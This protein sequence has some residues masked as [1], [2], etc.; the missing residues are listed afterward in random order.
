[1][2]APSEG[3][4]DT[5]LKVL[6]PPPPALRLRCSCLLFNLAVEWAEGLN[7]S[8]FNFMLEDLQW[9]LSG[10]R[11]ALF[12]LLAARLPGSQAG[13]QLVGHLPGRAEV[14]ISLLAL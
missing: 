10:G 6:N 3:G 12:P 8:L 11:C 1:M 4:N 9:A 7:A 14:C 5:T 13:L 2:P